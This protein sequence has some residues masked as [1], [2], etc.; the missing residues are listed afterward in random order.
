M[1]A[2]SDTLKA[3][4]RTG[5]DPRWTLCPTGGIG[6]VRA[7]VSLFGGNKLDV[8]VLA[9]QT[10]GVSKEIEDLRRS[11]ILKK[12]RVYTIADFIGKDESD[13]EGLFESDTFVAIINACYELTGKNKPTA[14]KMRSLC[15]GV[16]RLRGAAD[17]L[18][19]A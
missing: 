1:Q 19:G 13:I 5:L 14:L 6:N 9:N 11:E 18:L 16:R 15:C 8:A 10:K 7:F 3:R 4:K 12:G 2:L 17:Y